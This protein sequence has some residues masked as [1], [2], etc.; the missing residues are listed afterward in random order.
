MFTLLID[1]DDTLWE[2]NIYYLQCSANLE[3]WLAGLGVPREAVAPVIAYWEQ[4][5]LEEFGYSPLGYIE[6]LARSAAELAERAGISVTDE[7]LA[8]ARAF[9]KTMLHPPIVLMPEVQNTL[10]QLAEL[11]RL[12][13][14]TK[15]DQV[16]QRRKLDRS[17]L[18]AYFR[19]VY[20]LKEK[21]ASSY[22]DILR[23]ER[24]VPEMS[25]MVGNS[26]KSDINP[27]V[28]AGMNAVYIP[29]DHTWT[30]EH[31]ELIDSPVVVTLRQ[32]AD[33][34]TYLATRS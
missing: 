13:L 23:Q 28:M 7:F 34:P 26:P 21:D 11:D 17:G 2:S 31:E 15:G 12:I 6:A 19:Q 29:H 10:A 5:V 9:G 33:L 1:A 32:F 24:A 27:A 18:G 3:E 30:A 8:Q 4:Q 22:Q 20:I 16:L 14:V 25:F